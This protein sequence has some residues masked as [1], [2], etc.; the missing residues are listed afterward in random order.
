MN[1]RTVDEYIKRL[2]THER[3]LETK[4]S[5]KEEEKSHYLRAELL[6][7]SWVIRYA[8]DTILEAADHQNKW[9]NEMGDKDD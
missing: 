3:F 8:E 6:A 2:K 4:L 7:L 1:T 5:E 9:F